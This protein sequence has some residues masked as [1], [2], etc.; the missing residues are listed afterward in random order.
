MTARSRRHRDI[1]QRREDVRCV[2]GRDCFLDGFAL[3]QHADGVAVADADDF[4]R[5][6]LSLHQHGY[7][8]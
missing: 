7:G 4:A 2:T 3:T 1:P 5:E 6:R 8:Y